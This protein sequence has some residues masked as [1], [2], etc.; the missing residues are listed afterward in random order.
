MCKYVNKHVM[1][2][3]RPG[4]IFYWKL[5]KLSKWH[6]LEQLPRIEYILLRAGLNK[7]DIMNSIQYFLPA[8]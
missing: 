8:S 6:W 1:W 3:H 4:H 2:C 5:S 7:E